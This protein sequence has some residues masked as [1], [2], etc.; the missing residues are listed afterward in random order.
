LPL[1]NLGINPKELYTPK[2]TP[3]KTKRRQWG[4]EEELEF[5]RVLCE[6]EAWQKANTVFQKLSKRKQVFVEKS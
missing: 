4:H 3:K 1:G 2:S 6:N 5:D